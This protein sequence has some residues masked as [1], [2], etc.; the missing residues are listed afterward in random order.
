MRP[1]TFN[2][3][4]VR[5]DA[6]QR[7]DLATVAM[8]PFAATQSSNGR[9]ALRWLVE[10]DNRV[11][12]NAAI[13]EAVE[14]TDSDYETVLNEIAAAVE[15]AGQLIAEAK[16]ALGE[17]DQDRHA[18]DQRVQAFAAE[19]GISYREAAERVCE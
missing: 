12:L 4:P 6:Q 11:A 5:L 14:R 17:V 9:A 16:Q 10:P 15:A 8:R 1:E 3:P 13:T 18:L 19:H 2:G 7:V